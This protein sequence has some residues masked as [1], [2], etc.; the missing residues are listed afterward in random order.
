MP[1]SKKVLSFLK[2]QTK[3]LELNQN[4]EQE[5]AIQHRQGPM[6][7][8]AGPGSGKTYTLTQ[9]VYY[10]IHTYG[11]SPN[12][13]LVI[14]FTKQAALEMEKRFQTMDADS[15]VYFSTFHALFYRIL[16]SMEKFKG[17]SIC[18]EIEKKE[19]LRRS[20]ERT[21]HKKTYPDLLKDEEMCDALIKEI[22]LFKVQES[23]GKQEQFL[24]MCV[25]MEIFRD[26]YEVYLEELRFQGKID[27]DDMVILCYKE[28]KQNRE[29]VGQLQNRFHYFL[30]DE[31]Q[32]ISSLQFEIVRILTGKYH[33]LF[34]VGDDDQAI[35]GFRGASPRV[36]LDF[37]KY[38]PNMQLVQLK[39]NYRSSKEVTKAALQVIHEN[40]ERFQKEIWNPGR[41]KGLVQLLGYRGEEQ[42]YIKIATMMKK[43]LKSGKTVAVLCRTGKSFSDIQIVLQR[44]GLMS[45][46]TYEAKEDISSLLVKD[47]V[48]YYALAKG[49][50]GRK[51]F[52]KVMNKPVRYI[53]R[54]QVPEHPSFSSI[55]AQKAV[56]LDV[57]N[58]VKLL[59]RQ[60]N[61][62]NTLPPKAFVTYLMKSIGYE[63]YLM[64]YVRKQNSN[65]STVKKHVKALTKL[66]EAFSDMEAFM[67]YLKK[68]GLY[69]EVSREENGQTAIEG[70]VK[71]LT[72]HG[73]KGLEFDVVYLPDLA[74]GNV[75]HHRSK[76]EAGIEEERRLFYV[77]MTRAKEKLCLFYPLDGEASGKKP[78][79]FLNILKN[80][81]LC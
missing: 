56:P 21:R 78:S 65:I 19:Y 34:V 57:K 20:Y 60:C 11:I 59:E 40:K 66:A 67:D 50:F 2:P 75:P 62:L 29:L 28:L 22:G 38:Y 32:D 1:V 68:D 31:F 8:L 74:E 18:N 13:I 81:D 23:L 49:R 30:I 41:K 16:R 25:P 27:Y 73:A 6:M 10:L 64:E 79:R 70:E 52:L 69:G 17:I 46:R 37:K 35:Y 58:R 55:I 54:E 48:A 3:S 4:P 39:Q 9:R 77:A 43:D 51:E 80:A 36:M 24:S 63:S 61:L 45:G 26:L 42:E 53:A 15:T 7:V 5:K 14:T 44:H 12:Q 76:T 33:N 72:M 47:L 71:L